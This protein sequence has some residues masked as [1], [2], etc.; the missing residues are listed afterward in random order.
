RKK[1]ATH[2]NEI[3][4]IMRDSFLLF[5]SIKT[6]VK[7]KKRID[8]LSIPPNCL[9]KLRVRGAYICYGMPIYIELR[10]HK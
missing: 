5:S 3:Q 7:T 9:R 2:R 1:D 8:C 6:K 4:I 10:I